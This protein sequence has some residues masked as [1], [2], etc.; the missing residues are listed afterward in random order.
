MARVVGVRAGVPIETPA[1]TVNRLYGT[2][3]Q[4]IVSGCQAIQTGEA[5]VV[6]AGGTES[7]SRGRSEDHGD[8]AGPCRAAG[9]GAGRADVG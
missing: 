9:S 6:L 8:R 1:Y 4:A 5:S 3:V 2:G 7:M